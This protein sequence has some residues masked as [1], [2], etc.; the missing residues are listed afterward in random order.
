M[1]SP[2][3][4][5]PIQLRW[6]P[7]CSVTYNC[8]DYDYHTRFPFSWFCCSISLVC[9]KFW[10]KEVPPSKGEGSQPTYGP[11]ERR[12]QAQFFIYK[13]V[14]CIFPNFV[15]KV[16][17]PISTISWHDCA[18]CSLGNLLC[19]VFSTLHLSSSRQVWSC[20]LA[21]VHGAIDWVLW[22]PAFDPCRRPK[23]KP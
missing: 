5:F 23:G 22:T 21:R 9:C 18:D 20:C 12:T 14:F 13:S 3:F 15:K 16:L 10:K 19:S 6:V 17:L 4:W 7:V 2:S 11:G 1:I 8:A